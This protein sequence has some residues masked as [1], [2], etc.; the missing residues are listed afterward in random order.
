MQHSTANR[1]LSNA[2]APLRSS[3]HRCEAGITR[4]F[5]LK[6]AVHCLHLPKVR[7]RSCSP[8]YGCTAI[9]STRERVLLRQSHGLATEVQTSR[10]SRVSY[11]YHQSQPNRA[12]T[13]SPDSKHTVPE[14]SATHKHL[15]IAPPR[16]S[17]FY[18][19]YREAGD[20]SSALKI[21]VQWPECNGPQ[22]HVPGGPALRIDP[23]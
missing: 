21:A 16:C 8:M 6:I 19:R 14:R 12:L 4:S 9:S 22:V 11:L 2:S 1:P 13:A 18:Y 7:Y 23:A 20:C 3:H 15:P 5:A 17:R 10:G